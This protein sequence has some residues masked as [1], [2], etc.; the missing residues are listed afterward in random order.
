[1]MVRR[2]KSESP[3]RDIRDDLQERVSVVAQQIN[4]E[5]AGFDRLI[6]QLRAEQKSELEHLRAQLRLANKLI[7]FTVWHEELC[8]QLSARI[9]A[10][11]AAENLIKSNT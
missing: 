8:A 5:N 4:A 6:S 11:Q 3:M 9:A 2:S 1:M 10:A 7:D